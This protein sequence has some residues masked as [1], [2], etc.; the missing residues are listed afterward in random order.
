MG[1]QM[2]LYNYITMYAYIDMMIL[3]M[4]YPLASL[5]EKKG[6]W[7]HDNHHNNSFHEYTV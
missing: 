5:K 6:L 4:V 2:L 7:G 3:F 1:R